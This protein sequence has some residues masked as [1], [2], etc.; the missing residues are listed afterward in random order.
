M[1]SASNLHG[2][3]AVVSCIL[4]YNEYS[5]LIEIQSY[6]LK[7]KKKKIKTAG[8]VNYWAAGKKKKKKA[9]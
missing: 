1:Q 9:A 3:W 8:T 7:K 4:Q 2:V 5:G 6:L